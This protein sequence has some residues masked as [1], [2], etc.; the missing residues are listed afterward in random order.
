MNS[1]NFQI[2]FDWFYRKWEDY[3]PGNLLEKGL[4]PSQIAEIFINENQ[5]ELLE[6]A[7]R[8]NEEN[9]EALYEFM[10]LSESELLI[11]KYFLKLIK[12]NNS[13]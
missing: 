12:M 13:K 11:L 4:S 10:N 6:I 3:C 1:N 9:Y 2:W 5:N 8:I 7:K